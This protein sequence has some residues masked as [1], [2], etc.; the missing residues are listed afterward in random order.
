M[1]KKRIRKELQT[2]EALEKTLREEGSVSAEF[3][4]PLTALALLV[5][6][7]WQEEDVRRARYPARRGSRRPARR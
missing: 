5:E 1:G 7:G 4:L 6:G 3:D 2:F